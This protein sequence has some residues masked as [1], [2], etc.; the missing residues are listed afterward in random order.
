M[1]TLRVEA[2]IDIDANRKI[3]V[4]GEADCTPEALEEVG[5]PTIVDALTESVTEQVVKTY[6]KSVPRIKGGGAP[7]GAGHSAERE[8]LATFGD[9]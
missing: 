5:I 1:I 9:D 3:W 7:E 4:T 6:E 2:A 8:P